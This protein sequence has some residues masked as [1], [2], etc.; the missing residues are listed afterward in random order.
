MTT[1]GKMTNIYDRKRKVHIR[2]RYT[3][4]REEKK[5]QQLKGCSY[6]GKRQYI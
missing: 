6:S 4:T 3:Y 1:K 2:V 5:N